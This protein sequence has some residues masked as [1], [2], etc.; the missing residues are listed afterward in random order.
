MLSLSHRILACVTC[1]FSGL[2]HATGQT[3]DSLN[4]YNTFAFAD[5][6]FDSTDQ[7]M[8][9]TS[10]FG[11]TVAYKKEWERDKRTG[12]NLLLYL[13]PFDAKYPTTFREMFTIIREPIDAG[14]ISL[15]KYVSM[16]NSIH[17]NTWSKYNIVYEVK[18]MQPFQIDNLDAFQM[19][20]VLSGV[21]QEKLILMFIHQN[22][23]YRIEYT[24][25]DITYTDFLEDVRKTI[26]TFSFY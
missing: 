8:Q 22:Y 9:F 24:A 16:Q 6:Q 4:T 26:N 3:S 25:T 13:R 10:G 15:K 1:I 18:Q 17:E 21:S 14:S 7:V 2:P 20:S 11:Y 23:A 12:D 5:A 19:H